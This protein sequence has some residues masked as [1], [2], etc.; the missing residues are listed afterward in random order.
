MKKLPI[1]LFLCL[2]CF[3]CTAIAETAERTAIT[4]PVT[5]NELPDKVFYVPYQGGEVT[6]YP[7]TIDDTSRLFLPSFLRGRHFCSATA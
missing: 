3:A 7:I 6:V 4:E 2:L 1:I 5:E